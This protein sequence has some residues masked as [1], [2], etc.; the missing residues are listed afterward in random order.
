[1]AQE[2]RNDYAIS[3]SALQQFG[4]KCFSQKGMGASKQHLMEGA[5]IYGWESCARNRPIFL[6]P[7]RAVAS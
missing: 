2:V 5:V 7:P 3:S 4:H 6:L 1:M